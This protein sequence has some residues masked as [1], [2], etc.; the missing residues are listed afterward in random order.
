MPARA[1]KTATTFT[2]V[3]LSLLL[4]ALP[5]TDIITPT[6]NTTTL[7]LKKKKRITALI[8]NSANSSNMAA[9]AT[10]EDMMS[11]ATMNQKKSATMWI[12]LA[13]ID[14]LSYAI[15]TTDTLLNTTMVAVWT[16]PRKDS[17]A[18]ISLESEANCLKNTNIETAT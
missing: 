8:Q 9:A 15:L 5:H 6:G 18:G 12:I 3:Q 11:Q 4:A 1:M 16:I 17:G 7:M 2:T 13:M 14:T 10:T